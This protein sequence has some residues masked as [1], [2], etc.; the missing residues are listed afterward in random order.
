LNL[1]DVT[2]DATQLLHAYVHALDDGKYE[3]WPD[4]FTDRALYKVIAR[5]NY[6]RELPLAT[7]FCDGK[8]MMK[9]RI[10]AIRDALIYAPNYLRHLVS[11]LRIIDR[12]GDCFRAEA[13]YVVF[14][15]QY[16]EETKVFNSGKYLDEIVYVD[17]RTR[18][19]SKLVI[20]DS[21]VIPS[22]LVIP[23]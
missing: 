13:N 20:Y 7:M 4:F 14:S 15:T 21:L 6:E 5:D 12:D 9:D 1:R 3:Q 10:T 11:A 23:L 17:G 2:F 19:K 18:F 8:G 22:L 16:N